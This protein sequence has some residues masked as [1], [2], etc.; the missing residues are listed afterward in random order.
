LIDALRIFARQQ[1]MVPVAACLMG[2]IAAS[3]A[4]GISSEWW[5][6]AFCAAV[7]LAC[8]KQWRIA[9]ALL[10]AGLVAGGIYAARY[11]VGGP[12]DLRRLLDGE[13]AL[14]A[15]RG[16]IAETPA[17]RD[18]PSG[19]NEIEYSYATIKVSACKLHDFW[20][21]AQGR[22]AA[23]TRGE[24]SEDFVAGGEVEIFGLVQRP[25]GA[26]APGLFDYR[27]HLANQRVFFQLKCDSTND[28]QLL[29]RES[30]PLA[31]RFRRWAQW[32]LQRGLN[33]QDEPLEMIWAMALGWKRA[34]SGEMAEPFMRTGTMH[35]FAVSGLHV[36]C[37]AGVL[38]LALRWAGVSYAQAGLIA[39]P[40]IWFYTLATGWQ[41]S[42]IRSAIM[43]TMV[44][45]GQILRRPS[46]LLNSTAAAAALILLF[47][48][49]Q[50]FQAGFQLSF[51][52]VAGIAL[53]VPV[54]ERWWQG[55][56]AH[57][58]MLPAELRPRWRQAL[59]RPLFWLGG[60]LAVSSA[61]WVGALPL[62]AHYFNLVTPVSLFAN[63][64]AVPLSSLAL[65]S[66]LGSLLL[67][68]LGVVFNHASWWL[69]W[70]TIAFTRWCA[71]IPLGYF[72]AP[73][74]NAWF[75]ALYYL[76]ALLW[77]LP[78]LRSGWLRRAA[79]AGV[80]VSGVMWLVTA[81]QSARQRTITLLP[82][83]GTPIF[84]D[85]PGRKEDLLVDCS[86]AR[87]AGFS[88]R[89][90]LH[91]RGLGAVRN[92]AL[93]HGDIHHAGGFPL[94]F[95]EFSPAVVFT[96]GAGGRS[97]AYRQAL[98][99]LGEMP[100]KHRRVA[101]GDEVAGWRVLHPAAARFPRADD[102]A[103]VLARKMDGW[104]VLLLSDLGTRGQQALLEQGEN[105][106][107]DLVFAGMPENG[108][109]LAPELLAAIQPRVIILGTTR[110]PVWSMGSP[111][112]R[113]RL[114]KAA[115]FVFYANDGGAVT[116]SFSTEECRITAMDG[117]TMVLQ[118]KG[119]STVP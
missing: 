26:Q 44:A 55:W 98:R 72:F 33:A 2:G 52:V 28:W 87:E 66:T 59:D 64:L 111:E 109:P 15:V 34:F 80:A 115:E 105:L 30:V 101:A 116:A 108:E 79:W 83:A 25:A 19:T 89:R 47:Q 12:E 43:F 104:R 88:V 45:L 97:P 42:A 96:G 74:P 24:L 112:L 46:E 86:S 113:A 27:A 41:S 29:S 32:Q 78:P 53:F 54:F 100:E 119:L 40:L 18:F 65:A 6:G 10:S 62:T 22:L 63:L 3:R 20:Q 38:V 21:E 68:P 49:E 7:L 35:I 81:A 56:L 5:I 77:V 37:I 117:K 84:V 106:R 82:P 60:A 91:A 61:S 57:D 36:A 1:P 102:N 4:W 75:F 92:F 8:V 16:R 94:L 69:M 99:L 13:P 23:V 48:P 103:L 11:A 9:G 107:A 85:L 114:E 67:P 39:V 76:F 93:T 17:V 118:P 50:L 14:L 110:Y 95:A 71:E 31:D 70:A 73:N 90:F 58:P 51:V